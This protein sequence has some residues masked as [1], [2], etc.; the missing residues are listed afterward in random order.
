MNFNKN[1][2]ELL[3]QPLPSQV[4][5]FSE[6][7]DDLLDPDDI[8]LDGGEDFDNFNADDI[9]GGIDFEDDDLD[10]DPHE[11]PPE[12]DELPDVTSVDD[13]TPAE[14]LEGEEDLA[15][16]KMM[17]VVATP[18]LI[19][20]TLSIQECSDFIESGEYQIAVNEGLIL[21]SDIETMIADM[22]RTQLFTEGVFASPNQKFKMTK[23][24]KFNQL[25]EIALQV[26]A[27]AHHDPYV[28]T[29]DKAYAVERR[30]KAGWR[31]RY[32]KLA[33]KRA[34]N[35]LKNLIKSKSNTL[36]KAASAVIPKK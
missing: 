18:E 8:G 20:D 25:F 28:K 3:N 23:K 34:M 19:N 7:F 33:Y 9:S 29:L 24:A 15:A 36:K 5:S 1:M 31:K 26:E 10:I 2:E 11:I 30:I 17:N 35:Y 16:D 6:G 32:G 4:E 27:R 22:G 21:E 13:P 12:E 14:P